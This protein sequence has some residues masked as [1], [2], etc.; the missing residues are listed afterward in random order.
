M[1]GPIKYYAILG[2]GRTA[3]NPSGLARRRHTH[4]GFV[5]ESVNREMEW[6][7][8]DAIY[9]WERGENFGPELIEIS[10]PQAAELIERFR[11]R[12]GQG[13]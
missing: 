4:D 10:E 9:Q 8:T 7:F 5:D 3:E 1:S 11:E 6:V 12:W 13:T 2:S